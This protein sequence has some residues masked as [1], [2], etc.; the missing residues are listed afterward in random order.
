MGKG[1]KDQKMDKGKVADAAGDLLCAAS[2][3]GKLDEKS[4]GKYINKAEDYLHKY[5]SKNNPATADHAGSTTGHTDS[6]GGSHGHSTGDY[7]KM[8]EG[9]LKK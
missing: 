1:D 5:S 3:Y 4:Y 2:Q 6:G 8:A 9:F 7:F